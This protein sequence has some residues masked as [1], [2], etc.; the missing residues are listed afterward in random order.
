MT[1]APELS[2][3]IP[4]RTDP[5]IWAT[6]HSL[7][8]HHAQALTS[9]EIIVIDNTPEP[10]LAKDLADHCRPDRRLRH[11]WYPGPPSSCLYKE[12]GVRQARGRVVIVC[13]SHVLFPAG[14]VQRVVD[15]FSTH[16]D[17]KDLLMGPCLSG[18][19]RI[20]GTN[21]ML[22]ATEPYQLPTGCTVRHGVVTRGQALGVWVRD[23][24]AM[25]LD[26]EP[27][28]IMQQGTGVF[29][30][31]REHWPGFH[32]AFTGFGGNE[33]Y[34]MEAYRRQGGRVLC[35]PWLY[36]LHNFMDR[37]RNT[38]SRP[39]MLTARNYLVGFKTLARPDLFSAAAELFGELDP[40]AAAEALPLVD[41]DLHCVFDLAP[42]PISLPA[43][44]VAP[45][46]AAPP[47]AAAPATA[48]P[49]APQRPKFPTYDDFMTRW[50]PAGGTI[51]GSCPA[52]LFEFLCQ[53]PP[54]WR[55]VE[56]EAPTQSLELGCGLSTLAF[57]RQQGPG[58]HHTAVEHNP[59]WADRVRG[60][61]RSPSVELVV[62]P[63]KQT[64]DV[65][66]YD[67][68]PPDDARYHLILVDAPPGHTPGKT[69][70]RQ[71]CFDIVASHLA[72]GG[73]LCIDDTHRPAEAELSQR[74]AA[75]LGLRIQHL[76]H[77]QR[78]FDILTPE[79]GPLGEGPGTELKAGFA[80]AK[81]PPCQQC[82]F[83]ARRMN[84]W[85]VAGCRERLDEIVADI[86]TRAK[87][88]FARRPGL[89]G[90]VA[91]FATRWIPGGEDLTEAALAAVI[92]AKVVAAIDA[93]AAKE[94]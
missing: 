25:S 14:A 45:L 77:G 61:L 62:A 8:L 33:T 87:P 19:G 11:L 23:P 51:G 64:G 47:V 91:R 1:A 7:L 85:G 9:A 86:L 17:S 44:R 4:T 63:L 41:R 93:A 36:W 72:P 10:Q 5:V 30:F 82:E 69:P 29:A 2:I 15:Y 54:I 56:T 18:D 20:Q 34:L 78:A 28:E 79:P 6:V 40:V 89:Q 16:P 80:E 48:P 24:R 76:T 22:Y 73:I 65:E 90:A 46:S 58:T 75:R 12:A 71:G 88:W 38:Y 68:R 55:T 37:T 39:L 31:L 60:Q 21:Q 52:P 53:L 43:G 59:K 70:G 74:L 50:K 66:W 3:V 49:L 32:P 42:Q 13:D 57:D 26:G 94:T 84:H 92:R 27:F 83:L 67:W 35:A 81:F